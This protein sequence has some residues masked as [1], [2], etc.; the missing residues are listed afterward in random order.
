MVG[1]A[2]GT[3]LIMIGALAGAWSLKN[4]LHCAEIKKSVSYTSMVRK[5]A[6]SKLD[7]IMTILIIISI[8]GTCISE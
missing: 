7:R 3:I 4:I 8:S 5:I 6:G 1:F 2:L